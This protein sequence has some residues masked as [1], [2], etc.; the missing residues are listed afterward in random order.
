ME[1]RYNT[2]TLKFSKETEYRFLTYA[3]KQDLG[4]FR[5]FL[6]ITAVVSVGFVGV[7][8]VRDPGNQLAIIARISFFLVLAALYGITSILKWRS[9]RFHYVYFISCLSFVYFSLIAIDYTS[10]IYE[11]FL[12]NT[13]TA[14]IYFA[15]S[16]GG[17]KFRHSFWFVLAC[18]LVYLLYAHSLAKTQLINQNPALITNF[19]VA[20]FIGY[21]LERIRRDS[22]I[23]GLTIEVQNTEI[24]VQK[25]EL[26]NLNSIKDLLLSIVSHDLKSPLNSMKGILT[27]L[28]YDQLSGEELEELKSDINSRIDRT[29][30]FIQ[31]VLNWTKSQMGGFDLQFEPLEIY[32][33]IQ[34]NIHL[35]EEEAR[36]KNIRIINKVSLQG[37][38]HA[39]R[40]TVNVVIRNV[41]NN[42]IRRSNENTSISIQE[43]EIGGVRTI[44]VKDQGKG[45]SNQGI[46]EI[47]DISKKKGEDM[48]TGLGMIL[49]K[50]FMIKNQGELEIESS[51]GIGTTVKMLFQNSKV[52]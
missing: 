8:M 19:I 39:D 20:G 35:V 44:L 41:L 34:E 3:L 13:T 5:M 7:E 43:N 1:E 9:I 14:F 40:E 4:I 22:F 42:A 12:Y 24:E 26:S 47:F 50:E 28:Q 45:I 46:K 49:S 11:L 36:R 17:L 37:K 33:L 6:L 18:I 51:E 2:L 32:Q 10:G 31:S 25:E 16:A 21:F 52:A 15:F 38:I 29:D 48:G 30:Y 23:R 27:L